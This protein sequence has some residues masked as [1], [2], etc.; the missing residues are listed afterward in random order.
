MTSRLRE[1]R[2][3]GSRTPSIVRGSAPAAGVA[4]RPVT[5]H[6]ARRSGVA[7]WR[8]ISGMIVLGMLV[9][10]FLFFSANI[11]YIHGI[12]VAGLKYISK[13][14]VFALSGIANMHIFWIDPQEVR[15]NILR[16]PTIADATVTVGWPPNMVQIAIQEREPALVWEQASVPV[17]LDIQGRVMNMRED[18]SDLLRVVSDV[19]DGPL[20]VNVQIGVDIVTGALQLKALRNNITDLRYDP[21]K[22]LGYADGRG[23]MAWFGTGTEMP[24]KLGTYE[25]IVSNLQG[26]GIHPTEVNVVDPDAPFYCCEGR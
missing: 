2:K 11:F 16:S 5:E 22:G 4:E 24:E 14:E 19:S 1:R 21:I 13:E 12:G 20:G 17:W 7:G 8:F 15:K 9:V 10:I 26:R 18:R 6:G 25:A 3:T 23:W